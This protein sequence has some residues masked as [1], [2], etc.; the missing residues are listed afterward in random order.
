MTGKRGLS[1]L[2]MEGT[3]K[4]LNVNLKELIFKNTAV[5]R[6]NMNLNVDSSEDN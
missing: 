1:T 5:I 3:E 4:L 2:T 6:T